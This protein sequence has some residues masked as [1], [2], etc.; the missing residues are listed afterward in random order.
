MRSPKIAAK[1]SHWRNMNRCEVWQACLLTL[2]IEPLVFAVLP[3]GKI[4][5]A[6]EG[7]V[8]EEDDK[9]TIG[10]RMVIAVSHLGEGLAE[11]GEDQIH[12]I[13]STI[14]LPQ[15][16]EWAPV[17]WN[18]PDQFPGR[19]PLPQTPIAQAVPPEMHASSGGGV[20]IELPH[21]TQALDALF[22]IIREHWSDPTRPP[23]GD[24]VGLAIDRAMGWKSP[25]GKPSRTAQ[26]IAGM[27]R[28]DDQASTDKRSR[29]RRNHK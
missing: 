14:S 3:S 23:K 24:T 26:S 12:T 27:I 15:F 22:L 4:L 9:T 11:I 25:N 6:R 2:D 8:L 19:R 10:S 1:W 17:D 7:V 21:T 29:I 20:T 5:G 28:P 18:L 13:R 16:G